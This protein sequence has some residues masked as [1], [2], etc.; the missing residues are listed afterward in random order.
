MG[1][2]RVVLALDSG[3]GTD[4]AARA[5]R[6]ASWWRSGPTPRWRAGSSIADLRDAG[7]AAS[8]SYEER[9]LKAQLKMADRAGAAFVAI[10]GEQEL[11]NGTV[12]LRRLVDG[13]QKSVPAAEVAGW[14]NKLDGWVD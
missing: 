2:D 3:G 5:P 10:V 1:L 4:A 7:I 12:T 13:V 9:P 6:N 11:A 8:G 14:L